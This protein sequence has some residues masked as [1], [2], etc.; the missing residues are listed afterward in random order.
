[1]LLLIRRT[2]YPDNLSYPAYING[3]SLVTDGNWIQRISYPN[4]EY[5]DDAA[6]IPTDYKV[7]GSKYAKREQ[8]GLWWS[9]PGEGNVWT[10]TS[11]PANKF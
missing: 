2:G 11:V 8:Y 7:G 9:L 10:K 4:S 3:S 5:S 6:N 1:M